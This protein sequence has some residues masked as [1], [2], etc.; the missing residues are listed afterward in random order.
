MNIEGTYLRVTSNEGV[1]T[2]YRQ[3]KIPALPHE[4][5][6]AADLRKVATAFVVFTIISSV[7]AWAWIGWPLARRTGGSGI[8]LFRHQTTPLENNCLERNQ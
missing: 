6:S 4:F 2:S 3:D 7:P 8:R 5:S 1:V